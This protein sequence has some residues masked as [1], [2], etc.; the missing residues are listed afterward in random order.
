MGELKRWTI[1]ATNGDA[2]ASIRATD[3][4]T[5]IAIYSAMEERRIAQGRWPDLPDGRK[6]LTANATI[7]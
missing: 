2:L 4:Q 7:N 3:E 6:L 1:R 5:A